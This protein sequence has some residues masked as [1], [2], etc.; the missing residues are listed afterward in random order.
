M[1]RDIPLYTESNRPKTANLGKSNVLD[2]ELIDK[3]DLSY[4]NKNLLVGSMTRFPIPKSI[5]GGTSFPSSSRYRQNATGAE[6]QQ[7][8]SPTS[9]GEATWC[10]GPSSVR[11]KRHSI[12]QILDPRLGHIDVSVVSSK[13]QKQ[14]RIGGQDVVSA[15]KV[16]DNAKLDNNNNRFVIVSL[17]GN[18]EVAKIRNRE[19]HL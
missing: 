1:R 19:I 17:A 7:Q 5:S 6:R 13:M 16:L 9:N 18:F 3:L 4:R 11:Y 14:A 12:K 2:P 15:K 10:S 8:Y